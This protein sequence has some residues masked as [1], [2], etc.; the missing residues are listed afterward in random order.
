MV[1]CVR[2]RPFEDKF[3]CNRLKQALHTHLLLIDLAGCLLRW[4]FSRIWQPDTWTTCIVLLGIVT[5]ERLYKLF[6]E[7]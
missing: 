4:A 1:E 7:V 3:G 2:F 6:V 5:D